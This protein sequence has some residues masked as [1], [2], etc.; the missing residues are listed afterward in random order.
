[1]PAPLF[2][3]ERHVIPSTLIA[4]GL[5]PFALHR[6]VAIPRLTADDEPVDAS[7]IEP[8]EWAQEWLGADEPHRGRHLAQ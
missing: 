2:E 3:E 5:N 6:A 7:Q 4:H 1:V 8:D